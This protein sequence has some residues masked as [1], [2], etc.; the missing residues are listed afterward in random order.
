[1]LTIRVSVQL[2]ISRGIFVRIFSIFFKKD[3][4][5]DLMI[6]NLENAASHKN[7]AQKAKRLL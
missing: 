4:F 6:I 7:V 2:Q 3:C 5:L 1:M